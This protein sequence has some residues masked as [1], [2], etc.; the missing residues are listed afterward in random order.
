MSRSNG[1]YTATVEALSAEVRVLMVGSRQVTLSV[2]RQLDRVPDDEIEPFGRVRDGKHEGCD[3]YVVGRH[4]ETGAHCGSER[5]SL[6]DSPVRRA[7]LLIDTPRAKCS[8]RSSAHN[9]TSSK[10]SS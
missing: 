3:V 8:R 10:P 5:R 9:S 6:R 2:Y 4:R 1:T 7:G